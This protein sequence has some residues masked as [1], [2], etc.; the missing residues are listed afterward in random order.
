MTVEYDAFCQKVLATISRDRSSLYPKQRK[1]ARHQHESMSYCPAA[2]LSMRSVCDEEVI[3]D[4]MQLVAWHRE[5]VIGT[6]SNVDNVNVLLK[7]YRNEK[8]NSSVEVKTEKH[9]EML[10]PNHYRE[11][12]GILS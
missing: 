12:F 4:A 10:S 7:W 5:L 2:P 11:A 1:D 3:S 9:P 6:Q 8:N